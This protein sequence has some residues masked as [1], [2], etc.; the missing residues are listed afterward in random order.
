MESASKDSGLQ[1][2]SLLLRFHQVAV[3]PTQ[4]AH[5]FSGAPIGVTEMLRCAKQLKLRA[6]AVTEDWTGLTKLPLPA[7]VELKDKTF[8]IVAQVKGEDALVQ[9]PSE[10]RPRIIKRTEFEYDWT[11]R[12]VLMTRRASLADVARRFDITWFLQAMHKYRRLL[13]EVLLASFYL[14]LF[15]LVTP[16]FFQ[17]VTDKVLTH[18]GFTTLDVLVVGLITVTIF[19]SLMGGLAHL[20]LCPHHQPDRRRTRRAAVPASRRITD[21][22]FREPP[23]RRFR[24][25]GEGAG[26]HQEFPHEFGPDPGSR[27]LLHFRL[28][29]RDVLL[30][31][32]AVVD[33]GRLLSLLCRALGWR[34]A[35]LPPAAREKVRPG[36]GEPGVSG[37]KRDRNPDLEGNGDRAANAAALG[38]AARRLRWFELRRGVAWQLGEPVGSVHQQDRD[39]AHFIFW[40]T[41]RDRRP[42]HG[43]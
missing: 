4:I 13:A 11:G 38:R 14:Q 9:I 21:R 33:R 39:C 27:S 5:Q 41:S 19:E 8:L 43:R 29:G 12:V 20:R 3:D 32:D 2:L 24:R 23:C 35:D 40:R 25:A 15:G 26:K 28:S 1:C 16:L 6:R 22:L 7:V 36:R 17:V 42:A 30:L 31:A 34:D 18:R 37:R 10:N